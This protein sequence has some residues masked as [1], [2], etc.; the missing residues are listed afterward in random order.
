MKPVY[1]M[2]LFILVQFLLLLVVPTSARAQDVYTFM[3][4]DGLAAPREKLLYTALVTTDQ[5]ALFSR[6]GNQ[7]KVRS[8]LRP[9]ELLAV[10][11]AAGAGEVRLVHDRMNAVP[12]FPVK[13][14]TGNAAADEAAYEAA[15][16]AWIAAHPEVYQ[17]LLQPTGE[18]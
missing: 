7:F 2:K 5:E 15:K 1:R 10:L 12:P 16:A 11:N 13:Q 17:Q 8:H 14:H 4:V 9:E 18:Q 3:A 6:Q